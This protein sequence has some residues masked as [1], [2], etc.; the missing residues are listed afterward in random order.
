MRRWIILGIAAVGTALP[1][2]LITLHHSANTD[3]A[4]GTFANDCCGTIKLSE[5]EMLLNDGQT[6][7]YTVANDADG[8]YL[9]PKIYVGAVPDKG[10][11]MAGTRSVLKL[12]LDRLPDLTSITIYE[13]ASSYVLTRQP[14]RAPRIAHRASL[15]KLLPIV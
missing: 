14:P 15:C 5:G 13:G 2:A 10:L 12:R 8:P 4:N 6:V 3:G 1:L 9:L 11:E 7:R